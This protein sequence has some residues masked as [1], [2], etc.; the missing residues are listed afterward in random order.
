MMINRSLDVLVHYEYKL[1][2]YQFWTFKTTTRTAVQ[3]VDDDIYE[4][5]ILIIVS[6]E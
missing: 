1:K 2:Q 5:C 6:F 4:S 3:I